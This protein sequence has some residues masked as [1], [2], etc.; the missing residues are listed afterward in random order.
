MAFRSLSARFVALVAL[1]LGLA[2]VSA[3]A[4]AW[5]SRPVRLVVPYPPAGP[6]D[7]VARALQP[8][9]AE[10]LGQNVLVD[11][12][13]GG[14]TVI[15]SEMVARAP[16]DGK[17]D[18]RLEAIATSPWFGL[19]DDIVVRIRPDGT[20]GSKVDIRAKSRVGHADPGVNAR[21]V[22]EFTE[23]LNAENQ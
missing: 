15:G 3:D 6:V 20:G 17:G 12:R 16:S 14:G 22:R 4:Q 8:R 5:P 21:H 19:R 2:P 1:L 7:A 13:P 11:N 18:A 23:K 10:L 9:L